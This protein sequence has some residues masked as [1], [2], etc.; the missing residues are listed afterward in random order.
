M[1]SRWMIQRFFSPWVTSNLSSRIQYTTMDGVP[2][3]ICDSRPSDNL[4]VRDKFLQGS[5]S[6]TLFYTPS[7]QSTSSWHSHPKLLAHF[8]VKIRKGDV[9]IKTNNSEYLRLNFTKLRSQ[10]KLNSFFL[11]KTFTFNCRSVVRSF[12]VDNVCNYFTN[13]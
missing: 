5:A 4:V 6:R 13:G 10:Y 7:S 1:V 9:H 3:S 8:E 11:L 12:S 2:S